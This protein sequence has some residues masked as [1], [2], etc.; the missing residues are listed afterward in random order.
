MGATTIFRWKPPKK[1]EEKP[2]TK[3]MSLPAAPWEQASAPQ[4]APALDPRREL[5][6]SLVVSYPAQR[7]ISWK[8]P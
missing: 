2:G 6:T 1:N 4:T 5:P 8:V 3:V 7:L